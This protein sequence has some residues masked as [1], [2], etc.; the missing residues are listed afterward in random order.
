MF[1][2]SFAIVSVLILLCGCRSETYEYAELSTLQ[3]LIKKDDTVIGQHIYVT[4][5]DASS[6][7]VWKDNDP[8]AGSTQA[9]L[10]DRFKVSQIDPIKLLNSLGRDGWVA[11]SHQEALPSEFE[12]KDTWQLKRRIPSK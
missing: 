4:W 11:Y 1:R 3:I 8:V 10:K 12:T 7:S 6:I 5:N 2:L 9:H